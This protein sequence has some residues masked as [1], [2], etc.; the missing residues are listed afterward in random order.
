[1]VK[2]ESGTRSG[3][4]FEVKDDER[5]VVKSVSL[6]LWSQRWMSFKESVQGTIRIQSLEEKEKHASKDNDWA[7]ED[8][9]EEKSRWDLTC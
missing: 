2:A 7:I 5:L 4:V 8:S 6:P 1:M 3:V 9:I